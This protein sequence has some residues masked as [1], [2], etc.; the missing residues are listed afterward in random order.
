M[1]TKFTH[2]RFMG[3][4]SKHTGIHVDRHRRYT[5]VE[6]GMAQ[7]L[8]ERVDVHV[9]RCVPNDHVIPAQEMIN[10]PRGYQ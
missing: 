1:N 9:T 8:R 7:Q 10:E 4:T 6:L 5:L 2:T 3:A